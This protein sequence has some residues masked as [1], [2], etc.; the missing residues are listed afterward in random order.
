[1]SVWKQNQLEVVTPIKGY[2]DASKQIALLEALNLTPTENSC[3]D[4]E[5]SWKVRVYVAY[6]L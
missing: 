1:M 3:I 5:K 2:I 4:K 6:A